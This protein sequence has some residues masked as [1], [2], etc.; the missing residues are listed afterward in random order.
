M[1]RR[2]FVSL[3]TAGV[4]TAV[5]QARAT[6]AG[7]ARRAASRRRSTESGIEELTLAGIEADLQQGRWTSASLTEAYLT[8]IDSLDRGGPALGAVIEVNPDAVAVAHSLDDERRRGRIRGPLHGVPVLVKDNLDTADRMKTTAGSLALMGTT[9]AVDATVVRR[10]REAGAVV[11]GKTNLSEWANFR[12]ERSTSGWSARGGLTRNPYVLDRNPCGS[13]SGSAV[14]VAANLCA[15]AVGTETNG[16]IVSPASVNGIV[17]LKPTVGLVSRR[18]IIPISASQDTAGPMGRSVADVALLLE[19]MA[20][21]DAGDSATAVVE[22]GA[23]RGFVAALAPD[24]L[25]G[26]RIGVARRLAGFHPRVDV[27]FENA[28]AALKAGGAS[29]IEL[30]DA[31]RADGFWAAEMEVLLCEFKDGLNRYLASRGGGGDVSSLEALIAFNE[32]HREREMPHFGQE[33]F[34][35]A[36]AKGSLAEAA[37]RRA[38]AEV[39]RRTRAD[40]ID[41]AVAAHR[42]DAIVAPTMGPGCV[43]D[44]LH[45]DHFVGGASWVAAG[46]GYPSV[47]VPAGD[48]LGLPV[49]VLFFGPAF[50]EKT[51]LRLAHGFEQAT[52]A[53]RVPRYL[54]RIEVGGKPG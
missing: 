28:L 53:R 18:G 29:P 50:S 34:E 12:S 8:R 16:S 52:R 41:A 19:V 48:V 46:A 54:A 32:A 2:T 10:L 26:A 39:R 35:R 51:L 4:P 37:Y 6:P 33:L 13:S 36:Q 17:G 11:L 31:F 3:A 47:S 45:G 30:P 20:G 38:L 5:A 43:T 15:V 22:A 21:P 24:G 1:N 9:P 44:L 23:S 40:G 27:L 14:A 25:R 7:S 49:G 42:L